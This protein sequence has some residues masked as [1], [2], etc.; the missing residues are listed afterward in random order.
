M[1]R[2]RNLRWILVSAVLLLATSL[3]ST[4]IVPL[5]D[6]L[7]F[8]D[9]PYRFVADP[10]TTLPPTTA[11]QTFTRQDL[12]SYSATISSHESGPQVSIT[13][14]LSSVTLP[15]SASQMQLTATA[16]A[17]TD[18]PTPGKIISDVYDARAISQPGPAKFD[19]RQD[20]IALRAPATQQINGSV[21]IVYRPSNKDQWQSLFTSQTGSDIYAAS[22]YGS[23][24][25]AVA[26]G[27]ATPRATPTASG[28]SPTSSGPSTRLSLVAGLIVL[29]IAVILVIRRSSRTGH[30]KPTS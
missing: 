27:A 19:E 21:T 15:A 20:Q 14:P 7:G 9:E 12:K 26:V 23:G 1:I 17:P 6:G 2:S 5:Y 24:Q 28:K 4:H 3:T 13:L 29:F 25:Y 18:G 11:D 22:F 16:E 30:D 10:S 8:P